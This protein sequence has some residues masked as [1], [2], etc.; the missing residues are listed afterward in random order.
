M[1]S[2]IKSIA[3]C[4]LSSGLLAACG[5]E[6]SNTESTPTKL[7]AASDS[8]VPTTAQWTFCAN[9]NGNCLFTGTQN[10]RYGAG[11]SWTTKSLAWGASCNNSTFGDP[12]PGVAKRCE[13]TSSWGFCANEGGHC[14]FSG[15]QTVRYGAGSKFVTQTL[16]GG[17]ACNNN[18]FGDPIS[19][20]AKH[21]DVAPTTWTHCANENGHCGFSGTKAVLY[22]A[23]GSFTTRT[24]SGGASCN[25]GTFGDPISGV[26]KRC[27][28]PGGAIAD[29][30]G[31]DTPPPSSCTAA[32]WSAGVNYPLGTTVKYAANGNYYKV[33]NAGSN[34]SD[35]T[36]PTISTWYWAPTTCDGGSNPPP[37]SGFVVSEAQFNQM[38]PNKSSF[39]TYSGL[40]TAMSYYPAFATTGSDTVRKQEAAAF[41]ANVAHESDYLKAVREYNTANWPLYCSSGNCGGKQYYG[42]GPIQ[43]SWDYNYRTAGNAIGVDLLNNPDLVATDPA[44]AWRTGVWYWM[45]GTGNAGTTPHNAMVNSQGFGVTIQAINGSVECGG[46]RPDQVQVRV[47]NYQNYTAILGVPTGSNLYC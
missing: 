23:N 20:T 27:Y 35:G 32:T 17:A 13:V 40:L 39:Y 21:C 43:L 28:I 29:G 41:L 9:E 16:N 1:K 38:F 2:L 44:I 30:G 8:S 11:S 34:G 10:V 6:S 36:D 42:R 7:L 12:A 15:V 18:T 26:A 31:G 47:T 24:L 19:G 46:K 37:A 22:G 25:N 4:L 3:I 45:N 14:G 33:V 5:G